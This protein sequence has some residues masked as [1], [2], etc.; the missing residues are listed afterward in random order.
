MPIP[1]E[2]VAVV[3]ANPNPFFIDTSRTDP[4]QCGPSMPKRRATIEILPRVQT[5]LIWDGRRWAAT[6]P[7]STRKH[8][9]AGDCDGSAGAIDGHFE[10]AKSIQARAL[11]ARRLA[12]SEPG[13][14]RLGKLRL[15]AWT[16]I[17]TS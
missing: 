11:D 10:T 17:R 1:S 16:R 9:E 15:I 7:T 5:W 13:R 4:H 3:M 8:C 14:A 6:E 2:A 12:S